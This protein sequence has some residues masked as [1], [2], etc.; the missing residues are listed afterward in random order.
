MNKYLIAPLFLLTLF[1]CEQP[2]YQGNGTESALASQPL[3]Q[4]D[5]AEL[6]GDVA[7]VLDALTLNLEEKQLSV[8]TMA[9][10]AKG[11]KTYTDS[12]GGTASIEWTRENDGAGNLTHTRT[13][14]FSNYTPKEGL[15]GRITKILTGSLVY[16]LVITD[17][18]PGK[19]SIA[20]SLEGTIEVT[21]TLSNGTTDTSTIQLDLE[22]ARDA[23][24]GCITVTGS[25]IRNG[26]S[27][28]MSRQR[29][30]SRCDT[31][32]S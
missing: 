26:E 3:V 22:F 14:T 30:L 25:V 17:E 4:E 6:T 23:D 12:S 8:G 18:G 2:K 20:R 13:I 16:T 24:T 11:S 15:G 29:D 1:A 7:E 28:T 21:R 10:E 27:T 19:I 31:P 32:A 5:A 9:V